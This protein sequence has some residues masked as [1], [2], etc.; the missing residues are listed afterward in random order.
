MGLRIQVVGVLLTAAAGSTDLAC[1]V[2]LDH[3]FASVMT[4]NLVLLGLAAGKADGAAAWSTGI[5]LLGYVAGTLAGVGAGRLPGRASS[6]AALR[7][8][9]LGE[10]VPLAAF[11]AIWA[12]G[13][14]HPSG[15]GRW[16][17]LL[18][19]AVAM[20][21]QASAVL[22]LDQLPPTTYLTS[23]LTRF[24]VQLLGRLLKRAGAGEPV[25][26]DALVRLAALVAGA[27][28]AMVL[29]RWAPLWTPCMALG[30]VGTSL[31]FLIFIG[32][33]YE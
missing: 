18:C 2:Q 14:G 28:A 32:T 15:S 17:A 13:R 27:A 19:A 29:L 16:L 6:R 20:G 33:R 10:L 9:L 24:L 11:W 30:A 31:L 4:G 1:F 21:I 23:T 22:M 7:A 3:V 8:G 5:A 26:V 25:P 12:A